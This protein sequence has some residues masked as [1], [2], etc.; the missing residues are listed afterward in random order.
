VLVT[1]IQVLAP[2][3]AETMPNPEQTI[4]LVEARLVEHGLIVRGGFNFAAEEAAPARAVLLVG[5]GGAEYWTHFQAWRAQSDAVADPLDVWSRHVI[6]EAANE[7]GARAVYPND[8]PYMPFQ[9]WAMRAEGL[10]SSPLGILM[11]PQFGLWH[12]YRGALLFDRALALGEELE[13]RHL[14]DDCREKPCLTTCPVGAFG[15]DGYD[16]G[17]CREHV[18]GDGMMCRGQGC[19]ARN[20]CPHDAYRYPAEVQAFHM[21]AFVVG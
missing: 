16:V 20:A 18:R 3:T 14:C 5:H 1:G 19:I 12:A 8:R 7:V 4:N 13:P 6:D 17:A 15:A 2:V 9:Q 11:H 21:D 10:K